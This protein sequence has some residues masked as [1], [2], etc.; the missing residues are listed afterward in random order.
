MSAMQMLASMANAGNDQAAYQ[1]TQLV[2]SAF[3]MQHE[4]D[5]LT[6]KNIMGRMKSLQ[7]IPDVLVS[8]KLLVDLLL[9]MFVIFQSYLNF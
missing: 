6:N 5:V 9:F 1:L 8:L 3:L 4:A 2:D 7:D